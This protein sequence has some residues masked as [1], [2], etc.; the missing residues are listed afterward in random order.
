MIKLLHKLKSMSPFWKKSLLSF[1]VLTAV[2]VMVAPNFS[3]DK[4]FLTKLSQEK[5]DS[6]SALERVK[7][8]FENQKIKKDPISDIETQNIR[9]RLGDTDNFYKDDNSDK[10]NKQVEEKTEMKTVVFQK[11]NQDKCD[12]YKEALGECTM[13]DDYK[14]DVKNLGSQISSKTKPHLSD[15]SIDTNVE[16]TTA[17]LR[18]VRVDT[19]DSYTSSK[20]Q[21][22]AKPD[23][24]MS[25]FALLAS[26]A[27]QTEILSGR[28]IDIGGASHQ[29]KAGTT[30]LAVLNESKTITSSGE[31]Y[32]SA[33]VIG[34]PFD[35]KKFPDGVT[36]LLK[37]KLNSTQDG[38]E[39]RVVS[40]NS[41]RNNDK[42]IKCSGQLE[43]IS[44]ENALRG[45]VYSNTGWQIVTTAATT[46]LAGLSLSKI[47]TSATQIGTTVDMTTS[48]SLYQALSSAIT[49]MGTEIAGSF[50]RS[51]TQISI[52]GR[53]V[54]RILFTED[55]VW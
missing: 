12:P 52:P 28:T 2:G 49:S 7:A 34:A 38:I 51:G 17:D 21:T 19:A 32:A 1:S 54:V 29:I 41:R 25:P 30:V 10:K 20:S 27:N 44:G 45:E 36:I 42:S 33:S 31:Q 4:S 18:T 3:K 40:C 23:N 50:A 22:G 14:T 43:D 35:Q 13:G 53:V 39:G 47:T 55:S 26:S 16:I 11:P 9:K 37:L 8:Q 15:S 6:L 48:N 5:V 46:F 24:K